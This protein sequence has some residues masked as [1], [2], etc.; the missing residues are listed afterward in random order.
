M[1]LV[2]IALEFKIANLIRRLL[3]AV[4]VSLLLHCVVGKVD[5]AVCYVVQVER[6]ARCSNVA[7]S[8]VVCLEVAIDTS[9]KR[10]G[11]NVK[12][13]ALIEQRLVNVPLDYVGPP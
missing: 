2:Q 5:Q 6:T 9:G 1:L 7:F 3:L 11:P 4:I 10:I 8:V 13:A 12:L